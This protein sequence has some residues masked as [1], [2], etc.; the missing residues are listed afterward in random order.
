MKIKH[1]QIIYALVFAALVGG[2]MWYTGRPEAN[3]EQKSPS[4]E[5]EAAIKV[6]V[7]RPVPM[8]FEDVAGFVGNVEPEEKAK[9][10]SKVG[11]SV[12]AFEVYVD[13]GDQVKK[14]QLLA[15]L[16]PSLNQRQIEEARAAVAQAKAAV[17][18]AKSRLQTAERNY[19][20][21]KGLFEEEVISRQEMDQVEN[22][23]EVEKAGLDLAREQ[24][25]QAEAR[26]R[27]LQTMREYHN[28]VS[29]VDGIVAER[30]F[31][32]GDTIAAGGEL[33]VIS[34]QERVKIK[35]TVT[36]SVYPKIRLGQKATVK[37]DALGDYSMDASVS[38]ISPVLDERTRTAVVEVLLESGGM[39]KP[40]MF[41]RV[42][43]ALGE[44][45]GLG[46]EREA[47]KQLPGTS[48][49]YCFVVADGKA[50]QRFVKIG[51]TSGNM[52]EIT[53]GLEEGEQIISPLVRAILDGVPV[54][55][56]Q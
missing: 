2:Y 36:E 18:Q 16:D 46:I 14:G 40:G 54:E 43:L 25:R 31:D 42:D 4:V 22:E 34:K 17:A 23:Y 44:H 55:V 26:L 5:S 37:V 20:R 3:D 51:A 32:P 38:R 1:R 6:S 21:Y 8:T 19:A 39:L 35:G 47:I 12:T 56:V 28:V 13:V 50:K 48:E 41:A 10:I 30:F 11:S 15:E 24:L 27:Q 7:V 9:V 29:P 33:F 45:L 49:W 52:V 53:E